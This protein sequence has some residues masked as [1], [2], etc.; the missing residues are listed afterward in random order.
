[1]KPPARPRSA[2]E[3]AASAPSRIC[4]SRGSPEGSFSLPHQINEDVLKRALRGLQVLEPYPGMGQVLQQTGDAGALALAIVGVDELVT[5]RHEHQ[6]MACKLGRKRI[7]LLMQLQGQLL[8]AELVHELD[9][10]LD[11]ND[12][13]LG[14]HPDAVGH[15]LGLLDVVRSE[16]DGDT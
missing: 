10:V 15:V 13:A 7:E 4:K 3:C 1:W 14:D 5:I 12:V 6:I 8:L 2:T 9:L 11:E 16:D